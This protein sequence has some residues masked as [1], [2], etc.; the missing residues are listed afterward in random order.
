M[1]TQGSNFNG[2]VWY[3]PS[4][5]NIIKSYKSAKEVQ[6]IWPIIWQYSGVVKMNNPLVNLFLLLF[7]P[8]RKN[9]WTE[10]EKEISVPNLETQ[11]VIIICLNSTLKIHP[12]INNIIIISPPIDVTSKVKSVLKKSQPRKIKHKKCRNKFR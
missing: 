3:I 2:S 8:S 1:P 7:F 10:K 4:P 9:S 6:L 5:L 11:N 12:P